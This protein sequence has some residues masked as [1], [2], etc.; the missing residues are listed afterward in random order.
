MSSWRA[1]LQELWPRLQS[2]PMQAKPFTSCF[3]ACLGLSLLQITPVW[4]KTPLNSGENK[5]LGPDHMMLWMGSSCTAWSCTFL[6]TAADELLIKL[7]ERLKAAHHR[8]RWP[9]NTTFQMLLLPFLLDL[10]P[11]RSPGGENLSV[12]P[13]FPYFWLRRPNEVPCNRAVSTTLF[14]GLT[15]Q[16]CDSHCS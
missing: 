14:T 4:S 2:P 10:Y 7:L 12:S 9:Q 6:I 11:Y 1:G 5:P 3:Q 16:A 13:A 8:K 15:T